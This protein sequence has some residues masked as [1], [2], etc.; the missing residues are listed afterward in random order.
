MITVT[1][2]VLDQMVAAIVDEVDPE[3]I[4][5]FGSHAIGIATRHSDV[6]LLVVERVPFGPDRSRRAEL[7]CI[8]RALN[9]FFVPKDIL[10]Y[11]SEEEARWRDSRNHVLARSLREGRLLYERD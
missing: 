4:V 1:E 3:K 11:S 5:L 8:R 10:V 6:D 2:E 7:S 9:A